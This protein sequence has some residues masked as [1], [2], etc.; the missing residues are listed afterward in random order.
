MNDTP[1]TSN[2]PELTTHFASKFL[3]LHEVENPHTKTP[4]YFCSR[5][6]TP[7]EHKPDAVVIYAEAEI[8]QEKY[9]VA[10]EEYRPAVNSTVLDL[11]A[12]LI[13][14]GE[15]PRQAAERELKEETGYVTE[16]FLRE[17]SPILYSSPGTTDESFVM[18]YICTLTNVAPEEKGIKTYLIS[19]RAAKDILY[20]G[21]SAKIGSRLYQAL[22]LFVSD[23]SFTRVYSKVKS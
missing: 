11:P 22:S 14:A 5:K 8:G 9:L 18:V 19:T 10:V 13:D 23:P 21:P 20:K 15:T 4:Y 12:G 2:T 3:S 6:E 17:D 16:L 7:R 1:N